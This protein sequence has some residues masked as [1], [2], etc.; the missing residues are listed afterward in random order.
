MDPRA[1]DMNHDD[2]NETRRIRDDIERT[3][4][5]MSR[6]IDEIEDRLSPRNVM[7]RTKESVRRAGVNK[8]RS[9]VDKVKANPIPAAMA[10]IGLYLLMRD[11]DRGDD[12]YEIDSVGY[13]AGYDATY[14]HSHTRID[15]M[16][17]RVHGGVDQVRERVDSA[18]ERVSG[19]M[20]TARDR[21]SGAM[22][23]ARESVSHVGDRA[24][25]GMYRARSS[26]QD[27]LSSNPL[28]LGVAAVALGAIVGSL[29]PETERE[30]QLFGEHRDKLM[31][32]G[33]DLA[34]EGVDRAK[35][36]ASAVT[37]TVTEKAKDVAKDVASAAKDAA[38]DNARM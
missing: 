18:R 9:L 8:T 28:I 30:D 25:S 21:I 36:V 1:T 20:D 17:D 22:S 32:R 16:Q 31:D 6:T 24:S 38:T 11:H 10:G 23:S 29:I 14:G 3:Q 7:Q 19:A 15:A 5:E 37:S 26:G 33:R 4:R 2:Q 34:R 27:L 13:D 35:N 12:I